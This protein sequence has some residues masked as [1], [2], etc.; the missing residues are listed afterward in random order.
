MPIKRLSSVL[1]ADMNLHRS[2]N[3]AK[4]RA[5]LVSQ[6]GDWAGL[7]RLPLMLTQAGA[8]VDLISRA[9]A[10]VRRSWH[11]RHAYACE[12]T[13]ESLYSTL[14]SHLAAYG[15]Y[16]WVIVG[17]ESTLLTI[18]QA[19]AKDPSGAA[20][21]DEWFPIP[22][23]SAGGI[24]RICSKKAFAELA[25]QFGV[26]VPRSITCLDP[27]QAREAAGEIGYPLMLKTALGCAGNGVA[28]C[29]NNLQLREALDR[30]AD[31]FPLV[32]QQFVTGRLGST[33]MLFD[34]GKPLA[35]VPLYK[36]VCSP[37]PLGPSCVREMLTQEAIDAMTPVVESVG[38]MTQFHGVCGMDWIEVAPGEFV[39]LE[40][41]PRPT[42]ALHMA[43]I[44]GVDVAAAMHALMTR[45]PFA[46]QRPHPPRASRNRIYMF[47]Q[48]LTR[49]LRNHEL[50]ELVHWLPGISPHDIPWREPLLLASGVSSLTK[51]A[52][53]MTIN[54]VRKV[55]GKPPITATKPQQRPLAA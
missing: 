9:D 28:K 3:L 27:Q 41:N 29:E 5:L 40:F 13:A 17:D 30:F 11:I 38:R 54:T 42:P 34:H 53:R 15:P 8:E 50:A 47:P 32:V 16:D 48:H 37:E 33:Q 7:L 4:P 26:P 45:Q 44:A 6:R 19:A 21:V 51:L 43:P 49:C 20:W 31:R 52:G 36:A 24:E 1:W 46:P 12:D 18:A 55:V 25:T 35:W 14:K 39:V 2:D 23:R 22:D 10:L